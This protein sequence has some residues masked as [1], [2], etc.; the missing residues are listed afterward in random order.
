MRSGPEVL[1]EKVEGKE[2]EE[3]EVYFSEQT[4]IISLNIIYRLSFVT[5]TQYVS[6]SLF[7]PQ[8]TELQGPRK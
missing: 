2:E 8:I 6:F 4:G 3:E 7:V 1:I 5:E